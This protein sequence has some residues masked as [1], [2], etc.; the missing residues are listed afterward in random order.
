[1]AVLERARAHRTPSTQAVGLTLALT[2][3]VVWSG[4]F[5]IARALHEG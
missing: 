2:A 4:N 1:M 5:V 3:T